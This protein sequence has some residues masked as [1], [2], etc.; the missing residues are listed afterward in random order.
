MSSQLWIIVA[1]EESSETVIFM[2]IIFDEKKFTD[3]NA[4]ELQWWHKTSENCLT[5]V[6]NIQLFLP[7][8]WI[9]SIAWYIRPNRN[10]MVKFPFDS[11][12]SMN[13]S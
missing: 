10:Q 11:Q 5:L 9:L 7:W 3:F 8:L 13:Y 6:F 2:I 4:L 1:M 12:K